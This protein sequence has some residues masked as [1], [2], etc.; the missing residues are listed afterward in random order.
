MKIA[1][2]AQGKD[3]DSQVDSRFGRAA[4]FIII[5]IETEAWE[6]IDNEQ[7]INAAQGA[8]IQAAKHIIDAGAEALITGNVGP[9][10]YRV[11]NESGIKIFINANGSISSSIEDF[12][13]NKL[14]Q[15]N[16]ATVEGHM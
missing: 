13:N 1:I 15:A 8:G 3:I 2:T 6:C 10:A 4:N 12:K 7:N 9:K 11:L 5:D 16:Q 14:E